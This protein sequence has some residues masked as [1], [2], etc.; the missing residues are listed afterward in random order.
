[1]THSNSIPVRTSCCSSRDAAAAR[2]SELCAQADGFEG[3]LPVWVEAETRDGPVADRPHKCCAGPDFDPVSAAD[4]VGNQRHHVLAGFDEVVCLVTK[5]L[6]RLGEFLPTRDNSSG[7]CTPRH[8]PAARDTSY[9][10]SG[11]AIPSSAP[12]PSVF[13]ASMAIRTSWTFSS[14]ITSEV[15]L[16]GECLARAAAS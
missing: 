5:G 6:P 14:D 13:M 11:A 9:S 4:T 7:E 16:P 1:M 2:T 15:S 10:K 3:V 12:T 8:G